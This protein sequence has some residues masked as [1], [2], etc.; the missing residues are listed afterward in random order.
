MYYGI[1]RNVRNSAWQ[2]LID[3]QITSLPVDVLAISK[4]ANVRVVKNSLV[5]DLLPSEDG[6]A[7]YDGS[8]WIIIYRDEN[9]VELSRFI[10]A[11]ELGH[12]LLGHDLAN[13]KYA[14]AQEFVFQEKSEQQADA[15]ALRILCPACVLNDLDCY[16]KEDIMQYCRLPAKRAENRA[17]RIKM[18]RKK[19]VFLTDPVER[20]LYEQFEGYIKK[21]KTPN[22]ERRQ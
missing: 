16:S 2:C 22:R 1:Y 3:S 13:V 4:A 12:I 11:H 10:I 6:K 15:F 17:Q 8:Q 5:D 14:Q 9:L 21:Q 7:Y 18:L 20:Q 19:N